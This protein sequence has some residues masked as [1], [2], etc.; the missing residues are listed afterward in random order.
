MD[1][2]RIVKKIFESKQEGRRRVGKPRL[3]WLE[4]VAKTVK[5]GET[6]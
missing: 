4:D 2:G 1:Q 5:N 6:G 3:R